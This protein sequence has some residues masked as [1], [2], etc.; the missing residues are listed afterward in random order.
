MPDPVG[1]LHRRSA[2]AYFDI[3][4]N[5]FAGPFVCGGKVNGQGY[6][7]N[8]NNDVVFPAIA[9]TPNCNA[10]CGDKGAIVY[11]LTGNTNFPSVAV[12]KVSD[13]EPVKSIPRRPRGSGHPR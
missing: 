3:S 1:T 10:T 13:A 11:T 7:A 4:A 12:S 2:I 8:W 9:V 6:I 5:C